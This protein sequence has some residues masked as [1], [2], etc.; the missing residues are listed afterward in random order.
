M[1]KDSRL[2]LCAK[3]VEGDFVCDVGT[4]HGYL[5]VHLVE[6]GKCK[7]AIASDINSLP[8]ESARNT[9]TKAGLCDKIDIVLSDGIKS[10]DLK[11]VSDIVIAGM[12]G[13]LIYKI[14]ADDDRVKNNGISLILQPM[15]KAEELRKSLASSGFEVIEENACISGKF[16]YT[17]MKCKYTGEKRKLDEIEEYLGKLDL[18]DS[19]A[20]EYAKKQLEKITTVAKC[21]EGSDKEK[22]E[23][24]YKLAKK[25]GEKICM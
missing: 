4:D 6:S 24:L 11:G 17:V 13:E 19:Y 18:S 3:M 8:L 2:L 10:V 25:I 14:I 5:A 15:T 12:G 9:V 16:V 20:C 23:G 22:S 1:L 21:T 7:K